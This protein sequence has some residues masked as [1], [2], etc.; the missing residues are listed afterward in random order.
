MPAALGSALLFALAH[1]ADPVNFLSIMI[2]GVLY[3]VAYEYTRTLAPCVLAH[4]LHNLSVVATPLPFLL[5]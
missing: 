1:D 5:V 2:S 3:A 4:A